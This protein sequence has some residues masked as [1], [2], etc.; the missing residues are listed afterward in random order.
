MGPRR[1]PDE[2]P[3]VERYEGDQYPHQHAPGSVYFVQK[4]SHGEEVLLKW[5]LGV[6]STLFVTGIIGAV[7]MV[8]QQA[9]LTANMAN[10][11][12]SLQELKADVKEI[13]RNPHP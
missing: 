11:A 4:R 13:K 2:F 8:Q 6:V 3:E 12:N 5:L 10:L 1:T 9:A 7:T